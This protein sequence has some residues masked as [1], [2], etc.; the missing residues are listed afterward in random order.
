MC[1]PG[2]TQPTAQWREA[3]INA[4]GPPGTVRVKVLSNEMDALCAKPCHRRQRRRKRLL[5]FHEYSNRV[6][7]SRPHGVDESPVAARLGIEGVDA[8]SPLK[9]TWSVEVQLAKVQAKEKPVLKAYT[10]GLRQLRSAAKR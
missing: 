10:S 3:P 4:I 8:A 5:V 1:F 2:N 7:P 6:E 9:G